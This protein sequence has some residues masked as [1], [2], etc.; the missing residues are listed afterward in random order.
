MVSKLDIF[1][2]L[3]VVNIHQLQHFLD[4]QHSTPFTFLSL[5]SCISF[6]SAQWYFF[7][8]ICQQTK[9]ERRHCRNYNPENVIQIMQFW[10][11]QI[12]FNDIIETCDFLSWLPLK[13]FACYKI[14]YQYF[15]NSKEIYICSWLPPYTLCLWYAKLDIACII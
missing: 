3:A 11:H 5:Y 9:E 13:F 1:F 7:K 10:W 2:I 12:Y 15:V 8:F 6:I 4:I 14:T